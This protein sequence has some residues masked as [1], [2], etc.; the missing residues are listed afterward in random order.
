MVADSTNKIISFWYPKL[1]RTMKSIGS[2][3]GNEW[4]EKCEIKKKIESDR[5]E[6]R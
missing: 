2:L 4:G 3:A 6:G 5:K 1:C